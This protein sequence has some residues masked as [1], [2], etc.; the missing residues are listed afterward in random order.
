M[1]IVDWIKFNSWGVDCETLQSMDDWLLYV[2]LATSDVGGAPA[3]AAWLALDVALNAAWYAAGCGGDPPE[4]PDDPRWSPGQQCQK[5]SAPGEGWYS[6]RDA[7]GGITPYTFASGN[8]VK[9]IV[10]WESVEFGGWRIDYINSSNQLTTATIYNQGKWIYPWIKPQKNTYC[11]DDY[12]SV[13]EP[14]DQPPRPPVIP[15]NED[16]DQPECLWRIEAVGSHV[17]AQGVFWTRYFVTNQDPDNCPGSFYYWASQRGPVF[18]PENGDCPA[19]DGGGRGGGCDETVLTGITY[20]MWAPCEDP[21]EWGQEEGELVEFEWEIPQLKASLGIA[22]RLDAI[23]DMIEL[24]GWFRKFTCNETSDPEGDIRTICF[25]SDEVS[26]EGKSR[27]R[28]RLRYRS[29]SGFSHQGLVEHWKDFTWNAGPVIVQH[30]GAPWGSPKVWASTADEGKRVLR[31]AAGE[32]GFD[33]DQVGQWR[34]SGSTDT[35]LGMPGTMRVNTTGGY[36]WITERDG[37]EGR[38]QVYL[39]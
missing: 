22:N 30:L 24:S 9:E 8:V 35:R 16:F 26:P 39:T 36:Y 2:A 31:H 11:A 19:P 10:N 21:T 33:P 18:C 5:V 38:P 27:L 23:A 29:V 15:P 13:G 17:D 6:E 12:P 28:K 4:W 20:K 32:A 25:I 37:S 34:I 7:D 14:W 1:N 3:D